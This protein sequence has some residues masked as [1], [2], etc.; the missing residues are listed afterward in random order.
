MTRS[1]VGVTAGGEVGLA[2]V[3]GV[4]ERVGKA[5]A[6]GGTG[7]LPQPAIIRP[8]KSIYMDFICMHLTDIWKER[9]RVEPPPHTIKR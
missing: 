7:G 1:G 5:V 3:V 8:N 6:V 9:R 4:K 2:L